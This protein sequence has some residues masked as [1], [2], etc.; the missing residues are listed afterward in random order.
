[1]KHLSIPGAG[2]D[3]PIHAVFCV[4][5][6]YAEHA[7]EL[8]N[9][10]PDEPVI[11]TKPL[12]SIIFSGQD[13]LIPPQTT[14]VH[15]EVEIV[16]ALGASLHNATPAEALKAIAAVGV[17]LDMT[18]RDIQQKLKTKGL[19]WD[20][21]KGINTFT[22]IGSFFPVSE[23]FDFSNIPVELSVN[24]EVR[25]RSSSSMMLFTPGVLLSFL[26]RFFT[27]QA[28]DLIFTGTPKGVGRVQSGDRLYGTI[29]GTDAFVSA[30]VRAI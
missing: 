17:G 24:G 20:L 12:S 10:V 30:G 19:P 7:A 25:Q 28:G 21:A 11:F 8:Q 26:S 1:M 16:L 23:D 5:R 29:P 3:V 6:N 9:E 22:V 18:A 14:D 13:V 27:L 15:H 2:L 4:G